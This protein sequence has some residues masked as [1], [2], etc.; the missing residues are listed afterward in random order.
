MVIKPNQF[1]E[2]AT[3]YA[4]KNKVHSLRLRAN[5]FNDRNGANNINATPNI[6]NVSEKTLQSFSSPPN[7]GKVSAFNEQGKVSTIEDNSNASRP[8]ASS[9]HSNFFNTPAENNQGAS[10]SPLIQS[11]SNQ[12]RENLKSS[13]HIGIIDF[14]NEFEKLILKVEEQEKAHVRLITKLNT[15]INKSIL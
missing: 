13:F 14:K 10:P 3:E 11:A 8:S 6:N 4:K 15:L 7:R 1:S 12:L 9:K 5:L 2:I